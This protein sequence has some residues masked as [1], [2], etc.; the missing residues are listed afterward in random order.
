VQ[1]FLAPDEL[2]DACAQQ[3][4]EISSDPVGAAA[5]TLLRRF[6]VLDDCVIDRAT[7]DLE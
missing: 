4:E 6:R 5:A 1:H 7:D 2:T 3:R